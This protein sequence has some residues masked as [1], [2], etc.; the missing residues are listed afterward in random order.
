MD[1][2]GGFEFPAAAAAICGMKLELLEHGTKRRHAKN[3]RF[4]I[5][6]ALTDSL[7]ELIT[8]GSITP[9]LAMKVLL[10]VSA[11]FPHRNVPNNDLLIV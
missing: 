7:D 1:M 8:N 4:R 5:G 6:A 3:N 10:Q 9:Q 11:P 2:L